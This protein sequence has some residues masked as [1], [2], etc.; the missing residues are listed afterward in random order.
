MIALDGKTVRGARA[1][2]GH[3]QACA[4]APARRVR[5]CRRGGAGAVG[6]QSEEQRDPLAFAPVLACFDLTGVVVSVDAM[7]TQTDTATAITSAGGDYVFTVKGNTP[8]LQRQLKALPLQGRA[9]ALGDRHR[10]RPPGDPNH[11]GRAR[12]GL[13]RLPRRGP[14]RPG[15]AGP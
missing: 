5:P 6:H 12:P 3:R 13:G 10:T 15:S 4:P 2:T 11:Q 7:H 14:G 9:R 1:R 8:T